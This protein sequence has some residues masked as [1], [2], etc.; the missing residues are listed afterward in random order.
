[1]TNSASV[2]HTAISGGAPTP[3]R[4][5]EDHH[6]AQDFLSWTNRQFGQYG[7]VFQGSVRGARAYFVASPEHAQRILRTNWQNYRKG[8]ELKRVALLLGAGLVVSDGE[9]WRRQRRMIQP[10]FRDESIGALALAIAGANVDLKNRW[11]RAAQEKKP[12]NVTRDTSLMVLEVVLVAIFGLDYG[13]VAH[14]FKFLSDE[15][16]RDL[17]FVQKFR[18]VESALLNIVIERRRKN[19]GSADILGMLMAARDRDSDE[20]MS[21]GQLVKEIM[22]LIVAGHETTASVLNWMWYLL[23]Q[24]P[25]VEEKLSMELRRLPDDEFPDV[26]ELPNYFYTRQVLSE[27]LRLYPPGWLISRRAVR[28]DWLGDYFVP[29]GTEIYISIYYIQRHPQIWDSPDCF[30]PDRFAPGASKCRHPLSMLPFSA[31]PRNCIGEFLSRL[32]MQIHAMTM[33]KELRLCRGKEI[34][35]PELDAYVNL[36]SKHDFTMTPELK[37]HARR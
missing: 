15:S 22:T 20:A 18:S 12:V 21:D 27:T 30:D 19:V 5:A 13:Q 25:D 10:A 17:Q 29:A 8:Q 31:G 32:E 4:P 7:D 23:S 1:M 28:D 16:V 6:P 26:A 36:R 33:V 14:H 24:H 2:G 9:M 11:K 34:A 35:P 37:S 3:P